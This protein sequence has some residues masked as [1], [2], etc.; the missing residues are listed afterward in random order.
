MRLPRRS[1]ALL[2]L[3]VAAPVAVLLL[4]LL[5]T[6]GT[7]TFAR[8]WALLLLLVVPLAAW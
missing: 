1:T 7:F 6:S 3:L 4:W 2:S 5:R 8:P